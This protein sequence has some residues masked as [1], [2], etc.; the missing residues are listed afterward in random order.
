MLRRTKIHATLGPASS[1]E[2]VLRQLVEAGIDAC[3]INF[4]HARPGQAEQLVRTVRG[5]SAR[6]RRPIAIRQDLQGP[7]IRIG[8]LKE[9]RVFLEAGQQFVLTAEPLEGDSTVASVT[10]PDLPKDVRPGE[11]ILIDEAA[12]HLQV[13][14]SDGERIRC[15][16]LV[17]G[18]L[19]PRKGINLPTTRITMP[20][21]TE[22]DKEDLEVGIQLG[23]DYITLS[24]VRDARDV[25]A[26]RRFIE[27][28][29]FR[30]PIVS[31]I[32]KREAV[33]NADQIIEASDGISLARGDLGLEGGYQELY[34]IQSYYVRKCHAAGKMIQVGGELMDTMIKNPGPTRSECVDVANAV[35]QGADGVSLS[36]ETA[37]GLYPVQA[38]RILDRIVRRT[39]VAL[40]Y[41]EGTGDV[42][43]L[44]PE[45]YRPVRELNLKGVDALL[46]EDG[47]VVAATALSNARPRCPIVVVV[48]GQKANWLNTWWGVYPVPS[49][50]EARR[51]GLLPPGA[52]VLCV[53][54][55]DCLCPPGNPSSGAGYQDTAA[56]QVP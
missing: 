26:A 33:T 29:G 20:V 39:E 24:F 22:K 31:K 32:E 44:A 17:G 9:E 36:G 10:Y 43:V 35:L 49:V 38:V 52:R 46:V 42:Q 18:E 7:R 8:E 19:L 2:A 11:I 14:D 3:R 55:A 16:V 5:L 1:S 56:K 41:Y 40:G 23:V 47:D 45:T 48:E 6:Y 34:H 30:A 28:R 53:S 15:R 27:E 54:S 12:L 21:L 25:H 50:D 37:V 13:L 51:T 4:S